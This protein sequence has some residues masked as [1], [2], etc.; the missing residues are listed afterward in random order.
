MAVP[1]RRE[2]RVGDAER[3]VV[4]DQ[5]RVHFAA[6]R[7]ELDEFEERASQAL[8][9]RTVA[10]LVPLTADLP[11]VRTGP[12]GPPI[13]QQDRRP[14]E[15][16]ELAWRIHLATWGLVTALCVVIWLLTTPTGY[17]W[18]VWPAFGIGVSVAVHGI[19]KRTV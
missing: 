2:V 1:E 16:W 5:L 4:V 10:D 18:P 9:A 13:R 15:G 6:G 19:V 3:Q 12:K 8:A 14:L 17:F 7:L 11:T